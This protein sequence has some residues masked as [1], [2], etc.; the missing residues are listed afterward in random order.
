MTVTGATDMPSRFLGDAPTEIRVVL[1]GF[2]VGQARGV[3]PSHLTEFA[4][5]FLGA[6]HDDGA[7]LP[8]ITEDSALR[9]LKLVLLQHTKSTEGA[10]AWLNLGLALRRM[11]LYQTHDPEH[12]NRRR[13]LQALNALANVK[14][15]HETLRGSASA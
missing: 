7:V 8:D 11:A 6:L 13:L 2:A 4:G 1:D 9:T 14:R 10:G 15:R 3:P 12:V 5:K